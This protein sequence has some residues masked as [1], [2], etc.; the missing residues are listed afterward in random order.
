MQQLITSLELQNSRYLSKKR[1]ISYHHQLRLIFSLGSQVKNILE[2]GIFNSF[3]ADILKRYKYNVSTADIDPNLNP[4][5]I[6]DLT[7][8]ISHLKGKFDAI[9]LFQVLEHFPYEQSEQALKQLAEVTNRFLVISIPYN[10]LYL[11]LEVGV[12]IADRTRHLL[13]SIPKFWDTKPICDQ[14]YW[15]MGIK[16]YPKK[17]ILNSVAKAGLTV[18]EEFRDVGHPYHYFLVLEKNTSNT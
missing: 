7:K 14:H 3:F 16:G 2:I 4:D 12:S 8:D 9:V 5:I 17:R 18:K 6:L 11:G 13:F 1:L 15:E 10:T